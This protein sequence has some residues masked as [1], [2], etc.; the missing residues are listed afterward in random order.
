[1]IIH[2]KL[3]SVSNPYLSYIS[4]LLLHLIVIYHFLINVFL[5]K[6]HLMQKKKNKQKLKSMLLRKKKQTWIYFDFR[7]TLMGQRFNICLPEEF[8]LIRHNLRMN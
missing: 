3:L 4:K 7:Y 1:M 5:Y 8:F 2:R 6:T